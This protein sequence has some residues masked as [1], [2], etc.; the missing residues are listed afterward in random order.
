MTQ[1]DVAA[2]LDISTENYNRLEKGKTELTLTKMRKLAEI[3]NREPAELIADHGNVRTV[4][5]RQHVQAGDWAE[6]HLWEE[7]DCYDV[8]VPDDPD[9]RPF[10]LHGA[11][12]RGPSMNLRYPDGSALIYT[13]ILETG[14]T[15]VP[16]KRYIIEVE[17]PDGLRE[18]TVKKLFKD[19]TGK[20]WLLP[21][22]N[23]PRHQV[24]IDPFE[25]DGNIVR[26]VGKV[27]FSVQREE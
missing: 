3:F 1:A 17:R 9:L 16:G 21:E 25:G 7:E 14:E 26:V 15:P 18:A 22:S 24:P 6:S 23:D 10:T 13:D 4:R 11:E 12:S 8:Q 2:A 20:L 5:V 19:D 27:V